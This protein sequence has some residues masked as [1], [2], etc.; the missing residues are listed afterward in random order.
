MDSDR[1]KETARPAGA[2]LILRQPPASR[3]RQTVMGEA[4]DTCTGRARRL[5]R[6]S[7]RA[8]LA[9]TQAWYAGTLNQ[10]AGNVDAPFGT[11]ADRYDDR[12]GGRDH[13]VY[14]CA[15]HKPV[16]HL[17]RVFCWL[18]LLRFFWLSPTA[19]PRRSATDACLAR[20]RRNATRARLAKATSLF[21]LWRSCL[22]DVASTDRPAPAP[23]GCGRMI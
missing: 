17:A 6:L 7:S 15:A 19:S 8:T 13:A 16:P 2:A 5:T 18:F 1:R 11:A 12:R 9:H 23:F 20:R 10:D 4:F 21:L 14:T 3:N 22:C